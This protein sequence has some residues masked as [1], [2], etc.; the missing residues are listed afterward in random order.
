M[1]SSDQ[2]SDGDGNGGILALDVD[3]PRECFRD[4][5]DRRHGRVRQRSLEMAIGQLD[6]VRARVHRRVLWVIAN[7]IDDVGLLRADAQRAFR[8]E[9]IDEHRRGHSAPRSAWAGQWRG[10]GV[11]RVVGEPYWAW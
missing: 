10:L 8:V 6:F 5:L 7:I 11:G 1:N 4:D 2:V 3:L 9:D